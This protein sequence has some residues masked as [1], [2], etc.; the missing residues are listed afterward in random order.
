M[1]NPFA[2]NFSFLLLL[3][4]FL[5]VPPLSA[6]VYPLQVNTIITPPYT[7][8]LS[9]YVAPGSQKLM[10]QVRVNDPTLENYQCKFRLTIEGLNITL[11]TK[12]HMV[13]PPVTLE[14]GGVPQIFYGEDLIDYFKAGN[15]DFSGLSR[16]DYGHSGKLPEGIYKITI[17]VLDYHRGTVVSN[18]GATMVWMVLND[19]PLLNL[20]R[21][22]TKVEAIDPVNI[23]FSWTPRQTGSPNSAFSTEYTFRLVEVWPDGRNPNDAMLVSAPLYETTTTMDALVYGPAEPALIPGRTYAWQVQAKAVT[24]GAE[25][26]DLFRN[27]GKSEVYTFKFGDEVGIPQNLLKEGGNTTTLTL[28]WEPADAGIMP[29][30][31]RVRYRPAGNASWYETTSHQLWTTV[32]DLTADT[33]YEV[34]VRA[35]RGGYFSDYTD[36]QRMRTAEE[37][38]KAY[39]CGAADVIPPIENT[40]PLQILRPGDVIKC[41]DFSVVVTDAGL[42]GSLFAGKG[43]MQV[44]FLNEASVWVNFS[45]RINTDY[46]L[47]LGEV[48]SVYEQGNEG[49]QLIDSAQH[50]GHEQPPAA[51]TTEAAPTTPPDT[52]T[53]T[54]PVVINV[55]GT[56]DTVTVADDGTI[57]VVDESGNTTTYHQPVDSVTQQP[58]PVTVADAAGNEYTVGKDGGVVKNN[59]A[60]GNSA[61]SYASGDDPGVKLF[62]EV[63]E[64]FSNDIESW[65]NENSKGPLDPFKLQRLLSDLPDCLSRDEDELR[66]VHDDAI[67]YVKQNTGEYISRFSDANLK[68]L[69]NITSG[70]KNDQSFESQMTQNQWSSAREFV[71]ERLAENFGSTVLAPTSQ[72]AQT[73]QLPAHAYIL[74]TEASI[75]L[76][77]ATTL[78][79]TA[80]GALSGFKVSGVEY[81]AVEDTYNQL[82]GYITKADFDS[83]GLAG[84]IVSHEL[85][86]FVHDK[87]FPL[88]LLAPGAE[89]W[90]K[91]KME[92][93]LDVYEDCI[94]SYKWVN[95]IAKNS[96][97]GLMTYKAVPFDAERFGC[98]GDQCDMPVP[99]SGPGQSLFVYL[100]KNT[101]LNPWGESDLLEMCNYISE[102]TEG[103]EYAFYGD[104][105]DRYS[106]QT[107]PLPNDILKYFLDNQILSKDAFN[108]QFPYVFKTRD[109]DVVF[110]RE[111]LWEGIDQE[112]YNVN[113]RDYTM[114]KG[115]RYVYSFA[116]LRTR[117]SYKN[118][119]DLFTSVLKTESAGEAGGISQNDGYDQ[120]VALFGTNSAFYA[121]LDYAS[122]EADQLKYVAPLGFENEVVRITTN[123][124]KSSGPEATGWLIKLFQL[125]KK[126]VNPE[127]VDEFISKIDDGALREY[128]T[129]LQNSDAVFLK[130]SEVA[131]NRLSVEVFSQGD[132]TETA[133]IEGDVMKIKAGQTIDP[134]M[135]IKSVKRLPS[136]IKIET[137]LGKDVSGRVEE[138]TDGN[139][140]KW[141]RLVDATELSLQ[142]RLTQFPQLEVKLHSMPDGGK[143]FLSDFEYASDAI[144]RQFES[145]TKLVDA[146]KKMD[147][148]SADE[149]LRRNVGALDALEKKSADEA[150]PQPNTY[151]SKKYIDEHLAK[152]QN[153]VTKITSYNP[154]SGT[155]GPPGGTFV[156]PR[157]QA[158]EIIMESDGDVKRLENLLG[159][160]RGELGANPYRIDISEPSGLRMPSGNER[161]ANANW[162][163]GG[164]TSAGILEATVDQIQPGTYISKPIF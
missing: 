113:S 72:T 68:I 160:K 153:G 103:L 93:S 96:L 26:H 60:T 137:D 63:L 52:A 140:G 118:N 48:A 84:R 3:L 30:D 121:L 43:V 70:F 152:F 80:N 115:T 1:P 127:V 37:V 128:A 20:P 24:M 98:T 133:Y 125:L 45:G 4:Q 139:G 62:K 101:S 156:L 155:V 109:V 51:D 42:R 81:I 7:P 146:W 46:R 25:P 66:M 23:P 82:Y 58:Q 123:L 27:E 151:L 75:N 9:D 21:D 130:Q 86:V 135:T 122:A 89:V 34:E 94:C 158:D 74:P 56:I 108:K 69:E 50:I 28:Q 49:A 47:I 90:T 88:E 150:I 22:G 18:A 106:T 87:R 124:T 132:L 85:F 102:K 145:N 149:V 10:V 6:Q 61:E 111:D 17:E 116:D 147:D 120:Y 110:S 54:E 141:Y 64:D 78:Y 57:T 5:L 14:G 129:T 114:P 83:R 38:T 119:H 164:K 36:V 13:V 31:Y 148:V 29:D 12:E 71:C 126:A 163:P 11:R 97:Y 32:S 157:Y 59:S 162:I 143:K 95:K 91:A 136:S 41:G 53:I 2:R 76:P 138:V 161:G 142:T 159:L 79:F 104:G 131:S 144:A 40:S 77:D 55:P 92:L 33:P 65:L 117:K 44:P 107:E 39:T 100:N 134:A 67:P 112:S 154:N 73:F 15:L 8:Y 35:E 105:L 19:P 16:N 99:E